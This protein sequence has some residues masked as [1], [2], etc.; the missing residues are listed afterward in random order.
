[1]LPEMSASRMAT[2]AVSGDIW[3]SPTGWHHL[4]LRAIMPPEP[5]S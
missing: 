1:V 5:V 2:R 3:S 4:R